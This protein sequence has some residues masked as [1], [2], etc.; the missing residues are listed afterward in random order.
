MKPSRT[1]QQ[2]KQDMQT[3]QAARER[4]INKGKT[5]F[6]MGIDLNRCPEK[7]LSARGLWEEGWRRAE[8]AFKHEVLAPGCLLSP[9]Y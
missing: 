5:C 6:R 1:L 3:Q 7:E 2:L 4:L 8:A 9:R